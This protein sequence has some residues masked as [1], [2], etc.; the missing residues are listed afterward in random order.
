MKKMFIVLFVG[1][2]LLVVYQKGFADGMRFSLN[3]LAEK[4]GWSDDLSALDK[5]IQ[6]ETR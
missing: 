3:Y 5:E 4:H 6:K 2:T 1:V